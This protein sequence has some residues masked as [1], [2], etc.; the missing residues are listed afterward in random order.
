MAVTD[1][2]ADDKVIGISAAGIA[3]A[4]F[5]LGDSFHALQVLCSH[6]RARL[7]DGYVFSDNQDSFA[8]QSGW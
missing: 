4:L 1:A 3:I 5:R 7:S 6:G 8:R 2:V